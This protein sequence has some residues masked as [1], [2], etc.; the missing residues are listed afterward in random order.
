[1]PIHAFALPT[2]FVGSCLLTAWGARI[3]FR[4]PFRTT[5]VVAALLGVLV[6]A[7]AGIS[8]AFYDVSF[9]GQAYQQEGVYQ[10]A[11]GWNPLFAHHISPLSGEQNVTLNH[12]P[13]G[14]WIIAAAMYRLT[15]RIETG[16]FANLLLV[17]VAFS[18]ALAVLA[19]SRR[20]LSAWPVAM[21]ALVAANPVALCQMFT[22]YVDGQMASLLACLAAL[23]FLCATDGNPWVNLLLF[24]AAVLIIQVKFT[25]LVYVTI[26]FA[27]FFA[28]L[29]WQK[30]PLRKPLY[31]ALLAL[32]LGTFAFGMN[33]YVF[34]ILENGNPFYPF[35]GR[36]VFPQFTLTRQTPPDFLQ[37]NRAANLAAS[38]FSRSRAWPFPSTLK[39]P[40]QV[41]Q[42]EW[43]VFQAPDVRT[44]G[45]GPLFPAALVLS[46]AF[47]AMGM[48]Q[49]GAGSWATAAAMLIIIASVLPVSACWWAR[50]APQVWLVPL[51]ALG[52]LGSMVERPL[53]HRLSWLVS[54]ILVANVAGVAMVNFRANLDA[55][56][57]TVADLAELR[58]HAPFKV[59][60][61]NIRSYRFRLQEAGIRFIEDE[62]KLKCDPEVQENENLCIEH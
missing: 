19:G 44:G 54:L 12:F 1:M 21:A 48:W 4:R 57:G 56:R 50:Y 14:P 62:G 3:Y 36:G 42:G 51:V 33:P 32:G 28:L 55:T 29:A 37:A 9:D 8:L 43:T 11:H 24:E 40:W 39:L 46:W 22:F 5:L 25:G 49:G 53:L 34:N 2:A 41:D 52:F 6:A 47:L 26:L 60:F 35:F 38:I 23:C 27:G 18:M 13:K 7:S 59:A 30:R 20:K 15:G 31:T 58:S 16:K 17:C 45:F 10:L 61:G